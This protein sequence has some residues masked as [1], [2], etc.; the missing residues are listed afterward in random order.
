MTLKRL[1]AAP[2]VNAA[3][4]PRLLVVIVA[5]AFLLL[6]HAVYAQV[7]VG[8]TTT[9]SITRNIGCSYGQGSNASWDGAS[10]GT[11]S[12]PGG[13][14]SD[15]QVTWTT[16]GTFRLKRTFPSG[17]HTTV[18]YSQYYTV[19]AK[20]ASPLASEVNQTP[21]CGQVTLNYTGASTSAF[22][23]TSSGGTDESYLTS[24][25]VTSTGSYYV[26]IK[27][28]SSGCWS[29]ARSTTVSSIP[30]A[31]AGGSLSGGGT[32][33]QVVNTT[34]NLSGYSGIIKEFRYTENGG[35]PVIVG[36]TSSSLNVSFTNSG[37]STITRNYW[38][39]ITANGCEANS[40]GTSVTVNPQPA[41]SMTVCVGQTTSHTITRS[42]G[43]SYGSGSDATFVSGSGGTIS[44]PGGSSSS[45]NVSWTTPGIYTL[46]RTFPSQ[47]GT[48]E[49]IGE[50]VEVKARPATPGSTEVNQQPGN[51]GQA[52]LN[53]TGS[54][55]TTY[56]QTSSG[57][58]DETYRT[59]RTVTATGNY[60]ART[61]DSNGC[62]SDA[63]LV[64]VNSLPASPVGGTLSG[65]GNY[66]GTVNIT[67]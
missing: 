51:C 43:C 58:V 21:G 65:G 62:W 29:D 45:F 32:F 7:C 59:T 50:T 46:K 6:S 30:A 10:G 31:P 20:P 12:D 66:Y 49:I 53:Y 5:G 42:I 17:C 8:Q 39:V 47:C 44:D 34:L 54:S 36:N 18:I 3:R 48:Q 40:S 67:L 26:R 63:R 57:G 52:I 33:T 24:R 28:S 27:N 25:S 4:G 11:I 14:A 56:W 23:Q 15:F 13:S 16:T 61:K 41:P 60:H 55:T 38:A 37:A 64:T 22:W 19:Y 9:V 35:A 2:L 1:L